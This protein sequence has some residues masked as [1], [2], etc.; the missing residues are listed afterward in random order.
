MS[1]ASSSS[2][3]S[4]ATA[5]SFTPPQAA[6]RGAR[7]ARPARP[8]RR[9]AAHRHGDAGHGRTRARRAGARSER[10][11]TPVV[12]MSG[13]TEDAP[14]IDGAS[15]QTVDLPDEALLV[16]CA[17]ETPSAGAAADGRS[18]SRATQATQLPDR[19]RPPDGPRCGLALP[20]SRRHPGGRARRAGR[21]RAGEIEALQPA[22]ALID[23]AIEPFDGIE[24]ARQAIDRV[25]RDG[26]RPL[27]RRPRPGAASPGA[28]H[29]RT[30]LRRQGRAAR[31]SSSPRSP[32]SATE[33]TT[34]T[35][36][37]PRA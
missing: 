37:W 14:T 8:A 21:P 2:A 33:S 7:P 4:A 22:T 24:L 25:T 6:Y 9:R 28:R 12:F 36:R 19:R 10:P 29:R 5:T 23:I 1:C 18:A 11:S 31:R 13:Y 15:R 34:S 17:A 3:S 20:R 26:H 32:P 35:P 27:H 30:R 16:D